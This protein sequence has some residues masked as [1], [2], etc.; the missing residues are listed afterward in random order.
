M[1]RSIRRGALAAALIITG[2]CA[3]QSAGATAGTRHNLVTATQL[4]GTGHVN[5]Y[6]A[7]RTIRPNFLRTRTPAQGASAEVPVKVYVGGM[8]MID[9]MDHLR[10][11][12][13]RTVQEV[14]F[15]EPHQ[16]NVR[17]G[18]NNSGGALLIILKP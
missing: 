12:T 4:E 2:G 11:L 13:T 7:L 17:F 5:L 6:D 3:A 1:H 18:G 9:G 14:E 8:Q 16:A 10:Q 15:L